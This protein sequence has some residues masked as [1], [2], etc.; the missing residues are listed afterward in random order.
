MNPLKDMLNDARHVA[1][2]QVSAREDELYRLKQDLM[3]VE[4]QV[5]SSII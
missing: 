1:Q 4:Q 5:G 3:N 2:G